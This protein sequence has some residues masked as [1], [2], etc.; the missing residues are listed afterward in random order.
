M[1]YPDTFGGPLY[2]VLYEE[3]QVL[4]KQNRALK[5]QNKRDYQDVANLLDW[6]YKECKVLLEELPPTPSKARDAAL[7]I[8]SMVACAEESREEEGTWWN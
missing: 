1:N 8:K 7:S 6:I 5:R 3:N 4:K 2:S